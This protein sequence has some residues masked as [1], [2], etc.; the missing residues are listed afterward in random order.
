M[1]NAKKYQLKKD[2]YTKARGGFSQFLIVRC[3]AC[4]HAVLLYQKDGPGG[5][6]RLYLDKIHAP[7][8]LANLSRQVNNK[9]SLSALYC[10]K[11]NELLAVPMVYLPENRLAFNLVRGKVKKE[12]NNGFFPPPEE[13]EEENE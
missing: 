5:L 6:F 7:E 10:P 2:K 4:N 12:K 3:A 8:N 9:A 13:S 1:T 11:C